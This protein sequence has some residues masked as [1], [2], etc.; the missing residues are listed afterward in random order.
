M[1]NMYVSK[2]GK[3]TTNIDPELVK[4]VGINVSEQFVFSARLPSIVSV[5]QDSHK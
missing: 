2:G 5:L 3:T 1:R 4:C